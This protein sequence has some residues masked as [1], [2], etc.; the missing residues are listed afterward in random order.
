M[1]STWN[2]NTLHE[3]PDTLHLTEDTV[4]RTP[5]MHLQHTPATAS[6]EADLK[7]RQKSASKE[8]VADGVSSRNNTTVQ[9][10]TTAYISH[11]TSRV[12]CGNKSVLHGSR[13]HLS[14]GLLGSRQEF[15]WGHRGSILC[16][17]VPPWPCWEKQTKTKTLFFYCWSTVA[18][19]Q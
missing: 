7:A 9:P 5:N 6:P 1:S 17:K 2:T 16:L 10:I 15:R 12:N 18:I 14:M 13:E 8:S 11:H 4:H 3:T 19:N